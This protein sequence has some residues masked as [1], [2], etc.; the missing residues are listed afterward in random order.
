MAILRLILLVAIMGGLALLLAQNWSP[1]LSLVFLGMQS[2]PLP[3]AMWILFSTAAGAVTSLLISI[4]FGLSN[5]FAA[6]PRRTPSTSPRTSPSGDRSSREET[7]YRPPREEPTYRYTNPQPPPST[8]KT[9]S[10]SGS[11]DDW[12][13]DGIEDW[14]FEEK[15][16]QETT[17]P[18]QNTEVRD[19][20]IYER[21]QEP[22]DSYRSGSS[23]S[24]SY[25]EPKNSGVGKTESVYDA[26]YRVI[27]PP[28]QAP[29]ENQADDNQTNDNQGNYNQT[30]ENQGNDDDWGF[31]ED[32]FFEDE[33]EKSRRR[34]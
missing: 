28:Y 1:V 6:P 16:Q 29:T 18:R 5:Y 21:Q 12:E 31:L 13:T 20:N 15:R 23:Y 4:L 32:D 33:D 14:D 30:N 9:Q 8:S 27:I 10:R 2:Q 3:L 26:D 34:K 19:S 24:Y 17:P 25:R 11:V 22:K 7:T